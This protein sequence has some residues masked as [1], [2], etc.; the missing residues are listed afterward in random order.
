MTGFLDYVRQPFRRI[1]WKLTLSYTLVALGTLMVPVLVLVSLLL[2]SVFLSRDLFSVRLL[3]Q[4][5]GLLDEATVSAMGHVLMRS[6]PDTATIAYMVNN[7]RGVVTSRRLLSVGYAELWLGAT[8]DLDI[9][10]IG[11]DGSLLGR[12]GYPEFPVTGEPFDPSSV[13]GLK[14]PLLTALAGDTRPSRRFS[15][16]ESDRSLVVAVPILGSGDR[17]GD[18]LGAVALLFGHLPMQSEVSPHALMAAGRS[19]LFLVVAAGL[20]GTLFGWLTARGLVRRFGRLSVAADGWS[21]GDFSRSVD[22]PSDDELGQLGRRLNSMT[23]QLRALLKKRQEMAVSEERNRLARDLH[24]SAK[25]QAFAASAQLGAA[26]ELLDQ[27]PQAAKQH[28]VEAEKLVDKVRRELTD[29]ILELRP[30]NLKGS[31]LVVALREYAVDWAHQNDIEVDVRAAEERALPIEAEE[32]LFRIAQGALAN[33]ARHSEAQHAEIA[34]AYSADGVTMTITDDG[35]GFDS[36]A[37]HGG[38]GLSLMQERAALI[39]ASLTI[40]SETGEGTRVSVRYPDQA[41]PIPPADL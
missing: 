30:L 1:R 40:E 20:A 31:S 28:L 7:S 26:V 27:D 32:A 37:P 33:T 41:S 16:Q 36:S 35:C 29:L 18:V 14:E 12:T 13:P 4:F 17:D 25:Q 21:R 6:P 9:L 39:E 34:L 11:A 10:V 23:E 3:S 15:A 2:S 22:D 38:M 5:V 19:L 24:D 8:S